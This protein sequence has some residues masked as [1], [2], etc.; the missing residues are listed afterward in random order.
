MSSQAKCQRCG[1]PVSVSAI[2]AAGLPTMIKCNSCKAT[3]T[4]NYNSYILYPIAIMVLI[5][6]V[7]AAIAT[8]N[9]VFGHEAFSFERKVR[10]F[11]L[12]FGIAY[13]VIA[14]L[15]F[16]LYLIKCT[17]VTKSEFKV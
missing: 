1:A 10:H 4:F 13:A 2:F 9:T 11:Y 12:G 6:I 8:G 3:H 7:V 14:E 17:Q 16:A 15:L 5:A